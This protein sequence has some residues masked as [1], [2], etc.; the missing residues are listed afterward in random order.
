MC[1]ASANGD[2][3]TLGGTESTKPIVFMRDRI[4]IEIMGYSPT[5]ST[6]Y[7]LHTYVVTLKI[8]RKRACDVTEFDPINSGGP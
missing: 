4:P 1:T 2:V 6:K 3:V 7:Q 5:K 8:Y